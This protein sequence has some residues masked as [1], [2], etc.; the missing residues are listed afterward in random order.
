MVNCPNENMSIGDLS[1]KFEKEIGHLIDEISLI[2]KKL[3]ETEGAIS[4]QIERSIEDS[5]KRLNDYR[6]SIKSE[7]DNSKNNLIKITNEF[8]KCVSEYLKKIDKINETI[9]KTLIFLGISVGFC[10]LL[11]YVV[12]PLQSDTLLFICSILFG[13]VVIVLLFY[14][15]QF[16]MQSREVQ[17]KR[18]Q[19]VTSQVKETSY[20][21]GDNDPPRIKRDDIVKKPLVESFVADMINGAVRLGE[22]HPLLSGCYEEVR[23]LA[24]WNNICDDVKDALNFYKLDFG[25]ALDDID[26]SSDARL[27]IQ[28]N[29]RNNE[30]YIL[31]YIADKNIIGGNPFDS[32]ILQF[33]FDHYKARNTKVK[34][35]EIRQNQDQLEVVGD[36]IYQSKLVDLDSNSLNLDGFILI[37]EKAEYFNWR[38]IEHYCSSYQRIV[39][40]L[41]VINNE[42]RKQGVNISNE[43][44]RN[45]IISVIKFNDDFKSNLLHILTS[46]LENNLTLERKPAFVSAIMAL[47]LH[48]D[49][50]FKEIVCRNAANDE[51]VTILLAYLELKR[52]MQ[53]DMQEIK[54]S[55]LFDNRDM[56]D[57]IEQKVFGIEDFDHELYHRHNTLKDYL[58]DGGWFNDEFLLIQEGFERKNKEIEKCLEE[59]QE[60]RKYKIIQRIIENNFENINVNV[61]DKA[62]DAK[63]FSVYMILTHSTKGPLVPILKKLRADGKS[64]EYIKSVEEDYRIALKQNGKPKY[65]FDNYTKGTFIGVID[66][67]KSFSEFREEFIHDVRRMIYIDRGIP[68]DSEYDSNEQLKEECD[69]NMGYFILRITPSKYNFGI[70]DEFITTRDIDIARKVAGMLNRVNALKYSEKATMEVFDNSIDLLEFVNQYSVFEL[71]EKDGGNIPH[72]YVKFLKTERLKEALFSSLKEHGSEVDNFKDLAIEISRYGRKDHHPPIFRQV[73][74]REYFNQ[75]RSE[76]PNVQAVTFSDDLFRSLEAIST[77]W[78]RK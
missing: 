74:K 59:I 4:S 13:I 3:I 49:S 5:L 76:L 55:D 54:I 10:L 11:Y 64:E 7:G 42:L 16:S 34:W 9:G 57:A 46:E 18:F 47:I 25:N 65:V 40:E 48:P 43:F 19:Q 60:G 62:I 2:E 27:R 45:E 15:Y 35:D 39:K 37:L 73:L 67:E 36:I 44:K 17:E 69:L 66:R 20:H 8:E 1:L 29:E 50:R 28:N 58:Y 53:S 26:R 6:N 78:D 70:D 41:G 32:S 63:L 22:A 38:D 14:I 33:L 31:N 68:F 75:M 56:I 21:I 72:K 61:I 52:K 71:M 23:F 12:I 77:L 51:S 30:K 24:D